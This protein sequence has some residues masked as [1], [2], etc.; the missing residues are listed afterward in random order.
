MPSI[1]TVSNTL[2]TALLISISV[3]ATPFP[4]V[5]PSTARQSAVLCNLSSDCGTDCSC[6]GPTNEKVCVNLQAGVIQLANCTRCNS[7]SNC[8]SD[9]RGCNT[10]AKLCGTCAI[11]AAVAGAQACQGKIAPPTGPLP[12]PTCSKASRCKLFSFLAFNMFTNSLKVNLAA[13]AL[14]RIPVSFVST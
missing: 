5:L 14:V 13:S 7:D 10:K 2:V 9:P 11:R 6:I 8:P 4:F 12:F 3:A 1:R